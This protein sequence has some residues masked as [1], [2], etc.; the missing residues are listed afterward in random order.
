MDDLAQETHSSRLLVV[1][2]E[3]NVAI[4]VSEILR[5]EGYQVDT[6]FSGEDAIERLHDA[7]GPYDLV[8]TDLHME[9][10]DGLSV[11]SELRRRHPLTI[12]VVL[13]GFASLESAVASIRQ[14]AYDYLVKPCIIEDLRLT[15]RRG[16]EHRRLLIAEQEAKRR[17]E[18]INAELELRVLKQTEQLRI[19]NRELQ[20]NNEAKDIFLAT[21][22]H[23]L[24]TPLTPII[25]WT[26]LLLA[27]LGSQHLEKGLR[28]IER[29]ALTQAKLI[30]DLLDVSR[31]ITGKIEFNPER[32]DLRQVV[33]TAVENMRPKAA[34][35]NLALTLKAC[36]GPIW[37]MGARIR[38]E[39]I[40][41]NLISNSVKFTSVGGKIVVTLSE[42]A[43][44]ATLT[45]EDNGIGIPEDFLPHVFDT[46]RQGEGFPARK[47]DGL[48]LGLSI[49]RAFV[50]VHRGRVWAKS[51]GRG[52]GATF[53]VALPKA[54]EFGV[55]RTAAVG[56]L[57]LLSRRSS[58]FEDLSQQLRAAGCRIHTVQSVA[59]AV[60]FL[61]SNQPQA[62]IV[63]MG[64]SETEAIGM[65]T[66]ARDLIGIDAPLIGLSA[67]VRDGDRRRLLDLGFAE[68]LPATCS[69]D[70]VLEAIRRASLTR[71]STAHPA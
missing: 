40:V 70:V 14:G 6:S 49:V 68:L 54:A 32:L 11:L 63:D 16:L 46:F 64:I 44:D 18:G 26:R 52:K 60:E 69:A 56:P 2:D 27:N 55:V 41:W 24:R 36:P 20:R 29:N 47:H 45:V 31:I 53:T 23:E 22:S 66:E 15:V 9:G 39:Q 42:S 58:A 13:T 61:K 65:V 71:T 28:A 21:L 7:R 57:L 62:T 10:L 3:E 4:T 33:E 17:L 30:E 38:L 1:D 51:E 8:V 12:A 48:G 19:A 67:S 35:K 25:G 34:E 5:R 50:E 43:T 59:D 37:I